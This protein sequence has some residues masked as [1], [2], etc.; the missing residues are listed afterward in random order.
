LV[1]D[2]RILHC[3]AAVK[4][5]AKRLV[6]LSVLYEDAEERRETCAASASVA[7]ARL[8]FAA[9]AESARRREEFEALVVH[10]ERV[11]DPQA[12][13]A[14]S[15]CLLKFVLLNDLSSWPKALVARAFMPMAVALNSPR[16]KLLAYDA[17]DKAT[18]LHEDKRCILLG[19]IL[20]K[21]SADPD[22][23][24]RL[25]A[26]S[27]LFSTLTQTW[28]DRCRGDI[29]ARVIRHDPNS[30]VRLRALEGLVAVAES[31]S[32]RSPASAKAESAK[33]LLEMYREALLQIALSASDSGPMAALA[34]RAIALLSASAS[35]L[36][37]GQCIAERIELHLEETSATSLLD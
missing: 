17:F 15:E 22:P 5:G 31:L 19:E 29:V 28:G 36:S 14:A 11:W 25:A 26:L 30:S 23:T 6:K 32:T 34:A 10:A 18:E 37:H 35:P 27:A 24:V 20:A 21:D 8:A 9:H 3:A 12:S 7:S 33:E 13:E 2:H 16:L 4:C 1:F